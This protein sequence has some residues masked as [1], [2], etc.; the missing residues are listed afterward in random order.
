MANQI[1]LLSEILKAEF[2][3]LDTRRVT[4]ILDSIDLHLDQLS[5]DGEIGESISFIL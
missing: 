2:A 4:E 5:S 3:A 1:V